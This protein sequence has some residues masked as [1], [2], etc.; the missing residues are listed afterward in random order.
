MS[1]KK[2]VVKRAVKLALPFIISVIIFL[3]F[4]HFAE[5]EAESPAGKPGP[6]AGIQAVEI[7]PE[8]AKKIINNVLPT[9]YSKETAQSFIDD[10]NNDGKEEIFISGVR[11]PE[12]YEPAEE[13][14]LALVLP[15]DNKGNYKKLANSY[16]NKDD[17]NIGERG[18]PGING[19][20]NILDI[21]KDGKK[22]LLLDL[23]AGGASNEAFGIFKIDWDA[24]KIIWLKVKRQDG[25]IENTYFSEGGSATH[26]EA[27]ELKDVDSDGVLE[28]IETFEFL[29]PNPDGSENWQK[30]K[31]VYKWDGGMFIYNEALSK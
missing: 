24:K 14:F 1:R 20:D 8:L 16:F 23:A 9:A 28:V 31:Y 19:T 3:V 22:E 15:T 27:F 4:W 30:D 13:I 25:T 7:T 11:A 12:K 10:F 18:V 26:N 29:M 5:K 6:E 2:A 21:D 17:G